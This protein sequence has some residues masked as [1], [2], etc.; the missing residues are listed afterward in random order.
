MIVL[1]LAVSEDTEDPLPNHT[2]QRMASEEGA[3][4]VLDRRGELLCE[5][6]PA[7]ELT[8]WQQT[9][10]AGQ[11]C[12]RNLDMNWSRRGKTP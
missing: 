2:Q 10:I 9:G 6:N 11:R 12:V 3:P 5:L 4:R 7:I 1:I 8:D